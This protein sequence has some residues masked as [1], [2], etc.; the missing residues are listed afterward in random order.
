VAVKVAA[1]VAARLATVDERITRAAESA[2]RRRGDVT[3]VAVSKTFPPEVVS[4]AIAAGATDLG[5]NRAQELKRKRAVLPRDVRWHFIGHL[6]SNKVRQVVG[7]HL[8]HSVD[9]FG[10]AEA[11]DRRAAATGVVQDVLLEVNVSGESSKHGIEP[12]RVTALAR[13]V[14]GLEHVRLR[15]LMT[16]APLAADPEAARPVFAELRELRDALIAEWRDAWH[17]S[18]GMT[19]DLEVAIE[20][21]ATIV[22]VGEAIFGPRDA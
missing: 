3:L 19:R 17:L 8:I 10:L 20:E 16:M 2:G 9:R 6:Q 18:M 11:I 22:R 21:G 4:A 12:P 14:G 1:D 5:E 13:E 7:C 15:G